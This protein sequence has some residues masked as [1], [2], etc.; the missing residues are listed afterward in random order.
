MMLTDYWGH[1]VSADG[2]PVGCLLNLRP[3]FTRPLV[4]E[5]QMANQRHNGFRKL[6]CGEKQIQ[7]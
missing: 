6:G 1:Y 4:P 3:L 2:H 7:K 5:L